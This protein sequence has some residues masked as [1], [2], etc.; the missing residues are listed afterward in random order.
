MPSM[1]LLLGSA[2]WLSS[3][4]ALVLLQT[5]ATFVLQHTDGQNPVASPEYLVP[6][7]LTP[8]MT[9]ASPKTSTPSGVQGLGRSG[10]SSDQKVVK[11]DFFQKLSANTRPMPARAGTRLWRG[12]EGGFTRRRR[13]IEE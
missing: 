5:H 2:L 8:I 10:A 12:D 9:S 1:R 4:L 6:R 11:V 7:S 13:F 3:N